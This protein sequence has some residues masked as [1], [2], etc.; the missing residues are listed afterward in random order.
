[1][2]FAPKN[3]GVVVC[4]HVRDNLRPVLLATHYAD[5]DWAFTCGKTDHG[6]EECEYT[7]VGVG[8]L[9]ERDTTLDGI[10]DLERGYSAERESVTDG[11]KRYIDPV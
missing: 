1:M 9:T 3:L 4:S 2:K 5:G 7:L 6:D 10:A 8:H 11:W